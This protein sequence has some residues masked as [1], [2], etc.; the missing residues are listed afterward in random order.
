MSELLR[1]FRYPLT[2]LTLA[3]ACLLSMA[4]SETPAELGLGPRLLVQVATPLQ[5]AVTPPPLFPR[6]RARPGRGGGAR[7][8]RAGGDRSGAGRG[9]AGHHAAGGEGA[10][11]DRP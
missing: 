5:R 2:Y 7:A 9:R 3:V 4:S 6:A 1:R 11:G 8:G 10:A